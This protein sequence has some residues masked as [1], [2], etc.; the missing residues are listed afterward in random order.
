MF[1]ALQNLTPNTK[2]FTGHYYLINLNLKAERFEIMDSL[3]PEGNKSLMDDAR[4]IIGSIKHLWE[5]NYSESKFNIA[6]YRTVHIETP[7]QKTTYDCGYYMLKFIELWDGRR[8]I[9]F[10]T[11][12]MPN[13]RKQLTNKWL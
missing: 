9:T 5:L 11:A 2:L 8:T 7:M 4:A 1:P 12:D 10:N 6:N 13:I 3:R